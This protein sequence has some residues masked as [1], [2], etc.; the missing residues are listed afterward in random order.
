MKIFNKTKVVETKQ[1]ATIREKYNLT[2]NVKVADVKQ[3]LKDEYERAYNRE[4]TIETL[5]TK[6][7]ELQEYKIKYDAMLVISEENRNRLL[8]AEEK[9][10]EL[11][12]E[13]NDMK[14]DN[15]ALKNTNNNIEMNYIN[16][17]KEKDSKIKELQKEIKKLTPKTK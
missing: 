6:I 4:Q 15:R 9:I 10:K 7:K 14:E 11:K 8:N 3:Y 2:E 13:I 16:K 17:L 5:E 12:E 1:L